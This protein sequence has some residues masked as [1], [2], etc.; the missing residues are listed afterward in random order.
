[1]IQTEPAKVFTGHQGWRL[2]HL[3]RSDRSAQRVGNPFG[4]L[5]IIVKRWRS[6]ALDHFEYGRAIIRHAGGGGNSFRDPFN[7]S[8]DM[9]A[10]LFLVSANREL[11]HYFIS[12]DVPFCSAMNRADG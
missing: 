4:Q 5:R 6:L 10:Y 8:Q 9:L 2:N 1:M 12:D 11:H 3:I 7:G